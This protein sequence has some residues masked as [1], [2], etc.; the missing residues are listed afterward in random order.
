[1]LPINKCQLVIKTEKVRLQKNLLDLT[2]CIS[3][4][5][6]WNCLICLLAFSAALPVSYFNPKR[7]FSVSLYDYVLQT[8]SAFP[9]S[10]LHFPPEAIHFC[11]F[12]TICLEDIQDVYFGPYHEMSSAPVA[13][14]L[15]AFNN[16][17]IIPEINLSGQKM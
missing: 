8:S 16:P 17:S 1:M 6:C 11:K 14:E 3:V 4:W 15:K 9:Y 7:L 5:S 13:L 10:W 2:V 12:L